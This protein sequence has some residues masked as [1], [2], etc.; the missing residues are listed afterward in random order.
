MTAALPRPTRLDLQKDRGLTVTWSDGTVSFYPIAYLRKMSPSADA[1]MLRE[2]L[3]K[4]PLTVL[5]A[6]AVSSGESLTATGAERV[7]NYAIKILFSDGHD[8]G[9]YSWEYLRQIDPGPREEPPSVGS[10]ASL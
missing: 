9:L 1:R 8:T 10:K 6:G 5:P 2:E 4:N 7:G 3:A